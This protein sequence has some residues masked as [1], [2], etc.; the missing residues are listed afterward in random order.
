MFRKDNE[1][2]LQVLKVISEMIESR[3]FDDD[4]DRLIEVKT[5][6]YQVLPKDNIREYIR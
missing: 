5:F 4:D 6:T 1:M 2:V 3:K